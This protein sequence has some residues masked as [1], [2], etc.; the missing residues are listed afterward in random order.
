M[1]VEHFVVVDERVQTE[2]AYQQPGLVRRT[3]GRNDDGRWLVLQV[4]STDTAAT[5]AA[6]AFDSSAVGA[7]FM[8]LVDPDSI[9]RE[10]FVG[11]P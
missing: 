11:L 2:F 10:A 3:T 6:R 7:E 1:D 5:T 9:H 8:S 4:W